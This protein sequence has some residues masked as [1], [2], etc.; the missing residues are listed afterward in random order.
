MRGIFALQLNTCTTLSPIRL[1]AIEL[2][3]A[4]S[5]MKRSLIL[6]CLVSLSLF[7]P[8]VSAK[9]HYF[10]SSDGVNLHYLDSGTGTLTLVFIPGWLMPAT[11]F[12]AQIAD[13]S[14]NYRVIALDP[15]G[16][17]LS[18]VAHN[19]LDAVRRARDIQELLHHANV[20]DHVLI[21]WSLG[22]MEVLDYTVRY[23]HP[24]L[25]GLV[26]IDNSIGM[27]TPPSSALN[28]QRPMQA[29]AFRAYMKRFAAGMFK[30]PPPDGMLAQIEKSATQLP[31]KDSWNLLNKPYDRSYYKNAVMMADVPVWY[32]VTP[33][34]AAQSAEL[35][36]T[37]AQASSSVFDNAGHALFVDNANLF[38]QRLRLFLSSLP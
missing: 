29:P 4:I 15:R 28:S 12:D 14:K 26:L 2:D 3:N 36:Q 10:K 6:A 31:P 1:A 20:H 30:Q 19:K 24:N 27:A 23:K 16:Q 5:T 21:G 37:H 33:K 18:S 38:N 35:L 17:G 9:S 7:A 13:L 34:F 32:A 8:S 22:V 11:I 25:R